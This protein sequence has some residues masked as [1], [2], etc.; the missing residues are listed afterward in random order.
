MVENSRRYNLDVCS[1]SSYGI[2]VSANTYQCSVLESF[3]IIRSGITC[4]YP[5]ISTSILPN[6]NRLDYENR[7]C[8]YLEYIW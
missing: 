2:G 7:V 3:S 4:S 1:L 8:D 6:L 5:E